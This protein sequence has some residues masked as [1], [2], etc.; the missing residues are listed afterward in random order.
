[1]KNHPLCGWV[2]FF[3]SE[4][5]VKNGLGL[6]VRRGDFRNGLGGRDEIRRRVH[7]IGSRRDRRRR[8]GAQR[9]LLGVAVKT[10]PLGTGYAVW[11]GIGAVGAVVYGILFFGEPA[12]F[13]RLAFVGLIIVGLV[14]L[15]MV[16][17]D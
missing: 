12:T 11:T 16:S 1:M 2:T 5:E 6:S 7:E 8:H 13:A 3:L 9:R 15:K 4:S 17:A 10:L 14:G